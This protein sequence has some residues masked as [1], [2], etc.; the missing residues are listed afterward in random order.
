MSVTR[1]HLQPGL[2]PN[3][4]YGGS[5]AF[6]Q[7]SPVGPDGQLILGTGWTVA[8]VAP[9]KWGLVKSGVKQTSA[10][11][12]LT[13]M[14]TLADN[15]PDGTNGAG[16]CTDSF[17]GYMLNNPAGNKFR[18]SLTAQG[19]GGAQDVALSVRTW[20]VSLPQS[21][22]Q[23]DAPGG[24]DTTATFLNLAVNTPVQQ[25]TPNMALPL[26][27]YKE[28]ALMLGVSCKIVGAG[29][30]N[31]ADAMVVIGSDGSPSNTSLDVN[32]Q[33]GYPLDALENPSDSSY[34]MQTTLDGLAAGEAVKF[35]NMLHTPV[36]G[37]WTPMTAPAAEFTA[38]LTASSSLYAAVGGSQPPIL[39]STAM[40]A[41]AAIAAEL[42][43][44][45]PAGVLQAHPTVNAVASCRLRTGYLLSAALSAQS[46]ITAPLK[47]FF[48]LHAQLDAVAAVAVNLQMRR[49]FAAS[50]A[51]DAALS[52]QGAGFRV[53]MR[54]TSAAGSAVAVALRTAVEC[55]TAL[56]VP[57]SL[58]TSLLRKPQFSMSVFAEAAIMAELQSDVRLAS[59]LLAGASTASRLRTVAKRSTATLTAGDRISTMTLKER[60]WAR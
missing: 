11:F 46:S 22:P 21:S 5:T 45:T 39:L 52:A 12:T 17:W 44:V 20:R 48:L 50:L 31:S 60:T 51:A 19:A 3:W 41:Q 35:S 29:G 43:Q 55:K 8:K 34:L 6:L 24:G 57:T 9:T 58:T 15:Y 23:Y 18:G 59:A 14:P 7:L 38:T 47:G 54:S 30:S 10:V 33:Q 1:L 49:T 13:S 36:F 28:Q 27:K 37:D 32:I 25:V 40:E 26:G 4:L 42:G 16:F 2:L 56:S 53:S